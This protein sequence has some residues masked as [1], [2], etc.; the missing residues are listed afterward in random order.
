MN[1]YC[2]RY[3]YVVGA[4][5]EEVFVFETVNFGVLASVKLQISENPMFRAIIQLDDDSIAVLLEKEIV[6]FRF[7]LKRPP[8]CS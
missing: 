1:G 3:P 8:I 7:S 2:Q 4:S 5:L 6:S